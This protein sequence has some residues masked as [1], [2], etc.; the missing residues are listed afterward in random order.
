[1]K[2]V[3][4]VRSVILGRW[5]NDFEGYRNFDIPRA[6]AFH[7]VDVLSEHRLRITV[8]QA[9]CA[10]RYAV[11]LSYKNDNL[12]FWS[13]YMKKRIAVVVVALCLVV[14]YFS[15]RSYVN[16]ETVTVSPMLIELEGKPGDKFPVKFVITN[17]GEPRT[18]VSIGHC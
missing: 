9:R 6:Q 18:V 4:W 8:R 16:R 15:I 5:K 14:I 7:G 12:T 11:R 10:S 17:S 2:R 1:M 13:T 3:E